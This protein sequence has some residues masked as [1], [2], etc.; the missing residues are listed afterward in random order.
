MTFMRLKELF[1]RVAHVLMRRVSSMME[2]N[3]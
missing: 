3:N 2:P 1:P